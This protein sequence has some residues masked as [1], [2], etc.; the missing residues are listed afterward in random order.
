MAFDSGIYAGARVTISSMLLANRAMRIEFAILDG[1]VT[2]YQ[3][4]EIQR[5]VDSFDSC[6]IRWIK[7]DRSRVSDLV[8]HQEFTHM[9]YARILLPELVEADSCIYIDAD[10]L[11]MSDMREFCQNDPDTLMAAALDGDGTSVGEYPWHKGHV[12]SPFVNT[13]LMWMNLDQWR[14][15]NLSHEILKFLEVESARCRSADQNALNWILR[16]RIKVMEGRFNA[17]ANEIDNGTKSLIPGTTNIH[18]AS[19]MKPWKRPLP[20]LSHAAWRHFNSRHRGIEA[21]I[22]WSMSSLAKYFIYCFKTEKKV[23]PLNSSARDS[24]QIYKGYLDRHS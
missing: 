8:S 7:F 6:S 3:K 5:I 10:F 16:D 14:K 13:G 12:D 17:M 9:T 19:G 21:N 18:Y 23:I 1:G 4:A 22:E 15:Q 2:T 20:T 24:L 11:V